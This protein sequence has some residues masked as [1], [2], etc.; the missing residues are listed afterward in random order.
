MSTIRRLAQEAADN[1]LVDQT[2][3]NGVAKVREVKN[4]GVH[5][6]NWLTRERAA[7]I[8]RYSSLHDSR[9][10]TR[11]S[12]PGEYDRDLLAQV[13]GRQVDSQVYPATRGSLGDNGS[14]GQRK[15]VRTVPILSWEKVTIEE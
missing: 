10:N 7:E 2:L 15:P 12:D 3:A 13:E 1:G 9:W 5:M 11:S 4:P 8:D 14:G 6:G